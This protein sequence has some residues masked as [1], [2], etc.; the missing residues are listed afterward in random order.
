MQPAPGDLSRSS[1]DSWR[2]ESLPVRPST[3]R[4][5]ALKYLCP[6]AGAFPLPGGAPPQVSPRDRDACGP[7]VPAGFIQPFLLLIYFITLN[8]FAEAGSKVSVFQRAWRCGNKCCYSCWSPGECFPHPGGPDAE[9]FLHRD[10][11]SAHG[12]CSGCLAVLLFVQALV[13]SNLTGEALIGA[14]V[15]SG[16]QSPSGH[17]PCQRPA[18]IISLPST[19]ECGSNGCVLWDRG[20]LPLSS[21]WQPLARHACS[22]GWGRWNKTVVFHFITRLCSLLPC[23]CLLPFP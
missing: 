11:S 6:S 12:V 4:M 13:A 18:A 23:L 15:G 5:P 22:M 14:Q 20:S 8:T 1:L 10:S 19:S 17:E 21:L 3:D 2:S 7:Q 16:W 9:L